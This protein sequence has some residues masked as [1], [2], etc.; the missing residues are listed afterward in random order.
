[1]KQR[2]HKL[3]GEAIRFRKQIEFNRNYY[4][5][6]C[7]LIQNIDPIMA[8]IKVL[9]QSYGFHYMDML[10]YPM[11]MIVIFHVTKIIDDK[12]YACTMNVT[13]F[14]LEPSDD[15]LIEM[16]QVADMAFK[17]REVNPEE[18]T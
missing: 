6:Y 12:K 16:L 5:H 7:A 1:M 11:E 10:A 15:T 13:G 18:T 8:R 4:K 2:K 17:R 9:A 14:P 3:F